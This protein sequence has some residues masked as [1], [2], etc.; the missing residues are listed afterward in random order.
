MAGDRRTGGAS[1]DRELSAPGLFT[2]DNLVSVLRAA[3]VRAGSGLR[4][5]GGRLVQLL[6]TLAFAFAVAFA[7]RWIGTHGGSLPPLR[8]ATVGQY[9]DFVARYV[10]GDL[11]TSQLTGRPVSA[12]LARTLPWTV[13]LVASSTFVAAATGMLVGLLMAYFEGSGIDLSLSSGVLFLRAI[14]GFVL[15][16]LVIVVLH[17]DLGLIPH[18]RGVYEPGT[19]PGLNVQFVAGVVA[20]STLIIA[21]V[22]VT[23][24]GGA[25]AMRASAIRVLGADFVRVARVRGLPAP[26]IALRYV[27]QNAVL[28]L[29]TSLLIFFGELLGS[30]LVVEAVF[31]YPGLGYYLWR[32]AEAPD[33]NT[34]SAVFLLVAVV[35]AVSVLLADLTYA[36]IDP[37]A[38]RSGPAVTAGR[39][40]SVVAVLRR[41]AGRLRRQFGASRR[42]STRTSDLGGTVDDIEDLL[43]PLPESVEGDRNDDRAHILR[44]YLAT[45]ARIVWNDRRGRIGAILLSGFLAVGLLG[46]LLVRFPAYNEG[47]RLLQLFEGGFPFGTNGVGQGLFALMVH[48]TPQMF[49]M[50]FV[51]ATLAAGLSTATGLLAGYRGGRVGAALMTVADA[52]IAVP[53]IALT[54]ALM[55]AMSLFDPMLVGVVLALT[56]WGGTAREIRAQVLSIRQANYVEAARAAGIPTRR[57]L[58]HDVLPHVY[59]YAVTAFVDTVR[60]IVV[61]VMALYFLGG[62]TAGQRNEV[63]TDINWG[64]ILYRAKT[65]GMALVNPQTRF[66]FYLPMVAIVLFLLSLLLLA[67][68]MDQLANP[69]LRARHADR[70]DPED[71]TRPTAD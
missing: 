53:G 65:Y 2:V 66:W 28:P 21:A 61:S 64:V 6:V 69:R 4:A 38:S 42:A 10:H 52:V 58:S 20:H 49:R 19:V 71:D 51:G 48:G 67:Q 13:L 41:A 17:Y 5:H 50:A 57:I 18:S 7:I 55:P 32:A 29:Y 60:Y 8:A 27:G 47:P 59:P 45:P 43:D 22:V 14:P 39:S 37:R 56:Y 30:T 31:A 15:A 26:R 33:W 12:L 36:Y 23:H 44:V 68:S 46:P 62:F 1:T 40:R 63:L 25:L 9:V 16:L 11:G 54:M 34:L 70:V 35:V 24:L 3:A